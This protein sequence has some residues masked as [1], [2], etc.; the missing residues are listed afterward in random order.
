MADAEE[1][2]DPTD[3]ALI[4]GWLS[5]GDQGAATL[6]VERHAPAL[7]R[8]LRSLG[9]QDGAEELAQDSFVKAFGVLETLR[10]QTAP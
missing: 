5:R 9:A 8:F 6:L 4:E 10:G 3:G 7:V 1:V 2:R